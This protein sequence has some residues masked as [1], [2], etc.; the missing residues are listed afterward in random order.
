MALNHTIEVLES[1][2]YAIADK[3][4][5]CIKQCLCRTHTEVKRNTKTYYDDVLVV[6]NQ[7]LVYI[8]NCSR[9]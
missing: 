1:K 7:E 6:L 3:Q 5:Q 4:R 8:Y 2:L 9:G